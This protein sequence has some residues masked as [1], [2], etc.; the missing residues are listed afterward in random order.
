MESRY[1]PRGEGE[2]IQE[3]LGH[4]GGVH[5]KDFCYDAVQKFRGN[6]DATSENTNEARQMHLHCKHMNNVLKL[7]VSKN[8]KVIPICSV[9]CI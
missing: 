6:F 8:V 3:V 1:C 7:F 9:Y 4:M 5:Q 2:T